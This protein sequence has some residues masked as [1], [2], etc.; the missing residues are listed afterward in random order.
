MAEKGAGTL[1]LKKLLKK[2]PIRSY[3]ESIED[4]FLPDGDK[5]L[6]G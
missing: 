5:P 1:F 3:V 4:R 2:V 6:L